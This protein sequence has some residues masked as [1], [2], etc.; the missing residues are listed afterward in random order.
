MHPGAAMTSPIDPIRRPQSPRRARKTDAPPADETH[1]AGP[2]N[3]PVPVAGAL[4]TEALH[5][6]QGAASIDAQILGQTGARRGLRGGPP[7]I[8]A[9]THAYNKA[10]WSGAKDRRAPTG[11]KT[12]TDV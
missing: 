6:A 10:E 1:E 3:L 4:K 7:V 12:K 2:A 5:P 9:A 11:R 8:D